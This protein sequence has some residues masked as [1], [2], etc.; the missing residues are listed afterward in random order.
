[1]WII[2]LLFTWYF[3][4]ARSFEKVPGTDS[5][6]CARMWCCKVLF[7]RTVLDCLVYNNANNVN[8]WKMF[9]SEKY[10]HIKKSKSK[11]SDDEENDLDWV[12]WRPDKKTIFEEGNNFFV[13]CPD[14]LIQIILSVVW[15]LVLWFLIKEILFTGKFFLFVNIFYVIF[16]FPNF[17]M[18]E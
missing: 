11:N 5:N 16:S 2:F 3:F 9:H 14:N 4:T 8:I 15:F 17:Q 7:I 12:A 1:M 6:W 18:K 13:R 10:F